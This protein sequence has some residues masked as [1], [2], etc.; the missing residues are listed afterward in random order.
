MKKT[1][2]IFIIFFV[3]NFAFAFNFNIPYQYLVDYNLDKILVKVYSPDGSRFYICD[4]NNICNYYGTS[5]PN[6]NNTILPINFYSPDF[7]FLISQVKINNKYFTLLFKRQNN[8][9]VFY[10]ILPFYQKLNKVLFSKNNKDFILLS[11]NRVYLY[12]FSKNKI[13]HHFILTPG[14]SYI[15]ASPSL[16]YLAYYYPAV[17][18]N[19]IRKFVIFDIE[20]GEEKIFEREKI[21]YWDLLTE[22]NKL[23][24]FIDDD[25]LLFLSDKDNSQTLYI[26]DIK[27]EKISKLFNEDFIIKDFI[28]ISDSLYFTANKENRLKWNLYRYNFNSKNIEKI[29]DDI[30]YDFSLT[31]IKNFLIIKKAGELPPKIVL[32]DLLNNN[33]KELNI[34]IMGEKI[35]LGEPLSFGDIYSVILKPDN[36]DKDKEYNLL[37]W[38]H[39]GPHRQSSL[40]YHPYFNYGVFDYLLDKISNENFIVAKIDY[41]GSFGYGRDFANLKNKIGKDDVESITKIVNYLK[42]SYKIGKIYLMGNSYGGYLSLKTIY[43]KPEIFEGAISINGVADWFDL[44][45]SNPYSIFSIHFNGFPDE[46]NIN[47]YDQASIF[48]EKERLKNKKFLI[49]Y[50]EED[51]T[52]PNNQSKLF[53]E[54]Y[55]DIANIILKSYKEGHVFS[56]RESLQNICVDIFN[57]LNINSE[58]CKN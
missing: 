50:G 55:K 13:V 17:S 6:I 42:N 48:L 9:F 4:L 47:L 38:L 24:E 1:F 33:K 51:K 8:D 57:F 21:D 34:N 23:F 56:S 10:K 46:S 11:K 18:K 7:E 26:Y 54:N 27:N 45:N 2:V 37:I 12:D 29:L 20:K 39:G 28:V 31:K 49:I 14:F 44:I 15:T 32:I 58:K 30:A 43:E 25:K 19:P 22:N 5:T 41:K 52:I 16:K 53:Y 3:S 36:F 40:G 35:K